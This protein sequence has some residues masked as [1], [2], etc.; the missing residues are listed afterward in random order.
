MI[1]PTI[2]RQVW[3][4]PGTFQGGVFVTRG[5]QPMAATVVY[6][7]NERLVN[8]QVID[9]NG[10]ARP[11]AEVQL[12]QP[13]EPVPHAQFCEWMPYQKGQAARADAANAAAA[14]V[15]GVA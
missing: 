12:R 15:A 5:D 4:W 1:Q 11:I 3:F 9:H 14:N 8:L 7:H 13:E 10:H 2:G 6:V